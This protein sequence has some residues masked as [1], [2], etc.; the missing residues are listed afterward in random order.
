MPVPVPIPVVK[1]I[2]EQIPVETSHSGYHGIIGHH[3]TSYTNS[4]YE[5]HQQPTTERPFEHDV[6]YVPHRPIKTATTPTAVSYQR[7]TA[8]TTPAA[9]SYEGSGEYDTEPFYIRGPQKEMI[10]I[11]PVPYW[12]DDEGNHHEIKSSSSSSSSQQQSDEPSYKSHELYKNH[13]QTSHSSPTYRPSPTPATYKASDDEKFRGYTFNHNHQQHHTTP[14]PSYQ[15]SYSSYDAPN[16]PVDP[17]AKYYYEHQPQQSH[18][19]HHPDSDGSSSAL[20][21]HHYHQQAEDLVENNK[22]LHSQCDDEYQSYKYIPSYE[23]Q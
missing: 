7:F 16:V 19:H 17:E 13:H 3:P 23:E 14:A 22:Q 5:H 20:H 6:T 9:P 18:H 8:S 12:I 1:V 21:G 4:Q 2:R 10:K 15:S 11:V